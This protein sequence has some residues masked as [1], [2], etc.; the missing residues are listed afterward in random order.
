M[1]DEFNR[2]INEINSFLPMMKMFANAI[3]VNVASAPDNFQLE[4]QDMQSD[5]KLKQLFQNE[6]LLEFWSRL[7]NG[8]YL[9][10]KTNAQKN[11]SVCGSTSY[12]MHFSVK[13]SE[14]KINIAID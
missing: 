5:I 4:L 11:A 6:D 1:I 14:S 10:L 2:C 13:W 12:V 9:I 3:A 7:P 8:K